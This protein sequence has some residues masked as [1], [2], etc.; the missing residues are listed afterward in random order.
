[1]ADYGAVWLVKGSS[2]HLEPFSRDKLFLSL[3]NSC[4]HRPTALAD[5]GA[6]A[7]TVINK[8]SSLS[9]NGVMAVQS[10]TMTAKITLEHFDKPASV[11]YQAF[12]KT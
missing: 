1:M 5:A 12:H 10:I 2:G 9:N 3:H 4:Q 6:L 11:H 7:D 8:L